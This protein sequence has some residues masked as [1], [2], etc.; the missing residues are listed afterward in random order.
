MTAQ[1]RKNLA[2][3]TLYCHNLP[4]DYQGFKMQ[5]FVSNG[6]SDSIDN[7]CRKA[8]KIGCGTSA[9][10][11][12]HGPICGIEPTLK[13]TWGEY[14]NRCF[15]CEI[16]CYGSAEGSYDWLFHDSHPDDIQ[17]ACKRAAFL[18][19]GRVGESDLPHAEDGR[20]DSKAQREYCNIEEP[21]GFDSF[22]PDWDLIAKIAQGE[23]SSVN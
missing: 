18:L 2:I 12:G 5:W 8:E 17:L 13:E 23:E 21:E 10:F 9:C 16:T 1:Q 20:W 11:A 4:P 22:T 7:Y 6:G 15:G 3:L 14:I 19:Q